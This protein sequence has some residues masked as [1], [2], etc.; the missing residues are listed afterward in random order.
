MPLYRRARPRGQTFARCALSV[1]STLTHHVARRQTGV[2]RTVLREC[3]YN[4][5]SI[6]RGA[7]ALHP[8]AWGYSPLRDGLR[9]PPT[10]KAPPNRRPD[11][12]LVR[13]LGGRHLATAKRALVPASVRSPWPRS[14]AQPKVRRVVGL[15]HRAHLRAVHRRTARSAVLSGGV[16]VP[17][18]RELPRT[19]PQASHRARTVSTPKGGMRRTSAR[20]DNTATVRTERSLE[21]L[22]PRPFAALLPRSARMGA[23]DICVKPLG[24]SAAGYPKRQRSQTRSSCFT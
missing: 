15:A 18:S 3:T 7:V 20:G 2:R 22:R 9:A 14:G 10:P 12:S 21:H 11:A 4:V 24:A 17:T 23:R 6:R 5:V 19:L 1:A 8:T 13:F 16:Q